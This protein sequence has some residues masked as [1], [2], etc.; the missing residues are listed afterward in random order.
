MH[1]GS[2]TRACAAALTVLLMSTG[3]VA[4]DR[5][6]DLQRPPIGSPDSP[7]PRS[8]SPTPAAPANPASGAS[9]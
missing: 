2:G 3:L 6:Q 8:N 9:W 5:R 7:M 4:C 1:T